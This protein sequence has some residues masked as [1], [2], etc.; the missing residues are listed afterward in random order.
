[1]GGPPPKKKTGLIIGIVVAAVVVLG[2]GTTALILLLGGG[3]SGDVH[4]A[5]DKLVTALNG[6][7]VAQVGELTCRKP[8]SA[9]S[10]AWEQVAAYD[11]A[12]YSLVGEPQVDEDAGTATITLSFP[13][14][15]GGKQ[16]AA[17]GLNRND[18]FPDGW[19]TQF[20]WEV[21]P[22]LAEQQGI[23]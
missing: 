22:K 19:C 16:Q 23:P 18:E 1:M 7:N 21:Y 5:A 20:A 12:R 6:R 9:E 14:G 10:E 13:T 15:G 2:G 17:I 4:V 11:Q 8:T 3:G